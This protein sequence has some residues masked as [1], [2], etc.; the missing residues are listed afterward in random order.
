MSFI[1]KK[2]VFYEQLKFHANLSWTRKRFYNLGPG[3]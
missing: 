2:I 1:A 3:A